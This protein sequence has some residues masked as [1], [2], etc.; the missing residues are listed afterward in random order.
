MDS[1]V[2]SQVKIGFTSFVK[3]Q[4][5]EAHAKRHTSELSTPTTTTTKLVSCVGS[6]DEG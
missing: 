4:R 5:D 2:R 6:L 1:G 3:V